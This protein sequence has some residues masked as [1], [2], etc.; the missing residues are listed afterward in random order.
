MNK[1]RL[2]SNTLALTAL[3]AVSKVLGLLRESSLAAYYGASSY[4]DAYKIAFAVP[5]VFFA[6]ITASIV[7]TFIPVY[8]DRLKENDPESRQR[9]L[10]NIFTMVG[11][12]SVVIIVL[13]MLGSPV[14]VRL[15]APGIDK[16]TADLAADLTRI[17]I[18][19]AL[20]LVLTNLAAGY[21][22][23]HGHFVT[24]ALIWYPHNLII[25]GSIV[26][27]HRY[28]IRAVAVGSALSLVSMLFIQIPSLRKQGFK[29]RPFLDF[30]DKGLHSIG[31]LVGPVLIS[32]AFNQVYIV[33]N[34]VL[35]SG[36]DSGSI[37]ALDYAFRVN[38]LIT[39]IFILSISA[40]MYPKFAQL[41]HDMPGFINTVGKVLRFAAILTI[42]MAACLFVLRTPIIQ[43][44]YERGAFTEADTQRTAF[45]LCG[46]SVGVIGFAYRELLNK[47]FYALKD[48]RTAM[49]NGIIVIVMNIIFNIVLSRFLGIAGITFGTSL[50]AVLSGG[51][52]LVRL[53]RKIGGIRGRWIAIGLIKSLA[54]TGIMVLVVQFV[55]FILTNNLNLSGSTLLRAVNLMIA[56]AAGAAAYFGSLL[57]LKVEEAYDAVNFVR[58]RVGSLKKIVTGK[59][60]E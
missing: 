22:Q 40:V 58:S 30:K 54:A 8:S 57:L 59:V 28:G 51:M 2:I 53:R 17:I 39:N 23:S 15:M 16:V 38:A 25:I 10:N 47:A 19:A 45:A 35:A 14:I 24:P 60:L 50:A 27:F 46:L 29:Y 9:F 37:S 33:I 4:S 41:S 36:F 56:A 13:G 52:L 44:I 55:E 1:S 6:L 43:V 12:F 7:Q 21:L 49:I 20:F 48:T 5:D 32:T 18:P 26:F 42:P 34:K 3:T 11:L 31:I